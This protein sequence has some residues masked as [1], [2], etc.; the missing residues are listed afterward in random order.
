[1]LKLNFCHFLGQFQ[2]IRFPVSPSFH[3]GQVKYKKLF[4]YANGFRQGSKQN[5]VN[6]VISCAMRR[7][8][9]FEGPLAR[10]RKLENYPKELATFRQSTPV[11]YSD[12]FWLVQKD[13]IKDN[14]RYFYEFY[15]WS[16]FPSVTSWIGIIYLCFFFNTWF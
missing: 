1:V 9:I 13:S 16:Y 6:I 2:S 4:Q 8:L 5:S 10:S 15:C 12:K 7:K 3:G 11:K 14:K